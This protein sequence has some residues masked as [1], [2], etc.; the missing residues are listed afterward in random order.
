M[1]VATVMG[2]VVMKLFCRG[3][4]ISIVWLQGLSTGS[5]LLSGMYRLLYNSKVC[6]DL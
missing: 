2:T 3:Y 1:M 5:V 6:N 4:I